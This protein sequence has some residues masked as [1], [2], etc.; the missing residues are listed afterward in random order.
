MTIRDCIKANPGLS[1]QEIAAMCGTTANTVCTKRNQEKRKQNNPALAKECESVGIDFDRVNHFWYKG[2]HYSIHVKGEAEPTYAEMRDDIIAEMQA[3][4]P[5]YPAI[6][7]PQHRDGH[8]LIMNP[9]DIHI[10]KLSRSFETGED[11]DAQIAVQRVREGVH[12]VIHKAS[13]WDIDKTA[14]IIGN[15]V[16]HVDGPQNTTTKGTRQDV[17]SMWFE[18]FQMAKRIYIE[19]IETLLQIAPLHVQYDPSNHDLLN[20]FFLADTIRSHFH[21]TKHITWNTSIAHRKYFTYGANLIG[22]THG[23][24]AK[25]SDLPLL[26]AQEAAADWASCRHR[27]FYKHHIHHD[28]SKD[29]GSVNVKTV[30]SPSGADGYHHRNGYQHAP[31]AIEGFVH[32]K[33][34]GRIAM[35]SHI[36]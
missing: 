28:D 30:R 4:A 26:M 33:E 2:K 27:Y 31:K 32:H 3:H 1:N 10:G 29:F 18:N 7:H 16:L 23:D 17:G 19:T 36:F 20:G 13:G 5:A 12:G 6:V 15:D 25:P 34:H 8:L 14:L 11:Y 24:G 21:N 35:L 22:T 9:A